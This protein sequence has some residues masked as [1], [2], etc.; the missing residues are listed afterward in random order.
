MVMEKCN[1][2][3]QLKIIIVINFLKE[4]IDLDYFSKVLQNVQQAITKYDKWTW[5]QEPHS[6][7]P[8]IIKIK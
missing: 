5:S 8:K 4:L 7:W 1:K 3:E 2:N 6:T